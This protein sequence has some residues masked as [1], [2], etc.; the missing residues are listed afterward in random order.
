MKKSIDDDCSDCEYN[1]GENQCPIK[2]QATPEEIEN[3]NYFISW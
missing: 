2:Q 3:C 1:I